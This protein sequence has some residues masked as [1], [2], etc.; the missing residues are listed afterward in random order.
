M[1]MPQTYASYASGPSLT[2][3]FATGMRPDGGSSSA[4]SPP[5]AM[6][7]R[8]ISAP[9]ESR[10]RPRLE[11]DVD[12]VLTP[13]VA[14]RISRASSE[15]PTPVSAGA[16]ARKGGRRSS[17]A[18]SDSSSDVE[19]C[20]AMTKAGK[21]CRNKVKTPAALDVINP[22]S[23]APVERFCGV[24]TKELSSQ[25]GFYAKKEE[26]TDKWVKFDGK[27]GIY[28]CVFWPQLKRVV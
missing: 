3:Q 7:P 12:A 13:P 26:M 6:P 18:A 17:D 22:S 20:S 15:P 28:L 14:P 23:G 11:M 4:H 16:K 9:D 8:P 1:P 27:L 2:M 19:T 25:T 21:R 10:R 5:P 24:H